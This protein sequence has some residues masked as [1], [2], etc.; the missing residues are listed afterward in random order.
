MS[1]T[2][3]V[4]EPERQLL[5]LVRRLREDAERTHERLKTRDER[6]KQVCRALNELEDRHEALVE[7]HAAE[8]AAADVLLG[9]AM[10]E[11]LERKAA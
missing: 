2:C 8:R 7:A 6:F 10:D 5:I 4:T 9:A 11:L 1:W 3:G